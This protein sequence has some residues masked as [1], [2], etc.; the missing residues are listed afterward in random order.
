[1]GYPCF[2]TMIFVFNTSENSDFPEHCS[3]DSLSY[4]W[5]LF[6]KYFTIYVMLVLSSSH[7]VAANFYLGMQ[8]WGG[9]F[10]NHSQFSELRFF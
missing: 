1:M 9:S 7:I 6:Y 4:S 10:S 2:N 5:C 3:K 8:N